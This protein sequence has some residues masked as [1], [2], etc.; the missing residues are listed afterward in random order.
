MILVKDEDFCVVLHGITHRYFLQKPAI[1]S[2]YTSFFSYLF[3]QIKKCNIHN[4]RALKKII[5]F[6]L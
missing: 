5:F 2:S 3:D 6:I 1:L 4:I